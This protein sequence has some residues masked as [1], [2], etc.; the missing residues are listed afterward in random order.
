MNQLP[1]LQVIVPL[2]S[3]PLCVLLRNAVLARAAA[4]LATWATFAIAVL[5]WRALS[6][7]PVVSYPMGGWDPS[8]GIEYRVDA[9]TVLLL[10]VVSGVASVVIPLGPG[11][12]SHSVPQGR[13][14]LYFAMC[15]LCLAGLL[16]MVMTGDAFNVFVFLEISSLSSYCLI[17]MGSSRRALRAAFNYL[18]MGGLGGTFILIAIG[19][20][21]QLTGTL[22][23]ALLKERLPALAASRTLIMAYVFLTTG[24]ALKLAL[25]PLHQWLP[26]A[27]AFAPSHV[28]AF[29]SGT[30]TKVIFYLFVRFTF[31]VFGAAYVLDAL[32]VTS[33]LALLSIAAMFAGSLAAIYQTDLKRLLAY[34]SVAQVGY[35]T[36][37]LSLGSKAG[38]Q[39]GLLHVFAHALMKT[40]LFLVAGVF[41]VH[42]G[43]TQLSALRGRGREIPFTMGAFVVGGLALIGVPG[44]AGFI[45][46]WHLVR[47][48][49]VAERYVVGFAVL[50]SSL[51]AVAYVWKVVEIAFFAPRSPDAPALTPSSRAALLPLLA[52]MAATVYFGVDARFPVELARRGALSLLEASP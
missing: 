22:N 27:Y 35:L 17:A 4:T 50:V 14:A 33:V 36:L 44:T 5:Q 47:A 37:A 18:I 8:F 43:T 40:G 38:V 49:L 20:L 3:A 1:P 10:L 39:A 42:F 11:T 2:L 24:M 13:L 16:G 19:L 48:A 46:K 26:N 45:S 52:L 12:G 32:R 6:T 51:L 30:G 21:Y 28:S 9:A 31:G 15:L 41:V 29:L 25:F 23:M 7:V 34:S